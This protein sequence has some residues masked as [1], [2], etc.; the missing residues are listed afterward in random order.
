MSEI[1]H[2]RTILQQRDLKLRAATYIATILITLLVLSPFIISLTTAGFDASGGMEDKSEI[3]KFFAK[4][5]SAMITNMPGGSSS[6]FMPM[7]AVW[8]RRKRS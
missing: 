4:C 6:W 8:K 2:E 5:L 3:Q 7:P 1:R